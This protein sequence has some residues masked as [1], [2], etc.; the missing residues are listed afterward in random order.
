ALLSWEDRFAH[1]QAV[2]Y[3]LAAAIVRHIHETTDRG[4]A[5]LIFMPGVAEIQATI[6]ALKDIDGVF[7]LPLHAGLSASEQRRVFA[8]PSK[9]EQGRKV[10]VATNIAETS[11]TI[12]DIGFVVDSGRVRELRH[13][14][15]TRVARLTTVL[16][17]QAAAAQRRGRAGRT[18]P[19]VCFRM[20]T[21]AIHERMPLHADPEILR[22]PLEQV[23]L[24][25]KA[26]GHDDPRSILQS[27]L[28]PPSP[29]AIASA[30]Q[31]LVA[32]GACTA[33][34]RPLTALGRFIA[35]IPVD[36]R[37]AKILVYGAMMGVLDDALKIVALMALDKPLFSGGGGDRDAVKQARLR[38]ASDS[39][40][41]GL[42]DWLADLAAY[43]S[44]ADIRGGGGTKACYDACVSPAAIRDVKTNVRQLRD[45]IRH[46]GLVEPQLEGTAAVAASPMVLKALICAG[47]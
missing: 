27:A 29:L 13:D 34:Y 8:K 16:C 12:D 17:S 31:L 44:L 4:L 39:K 5:V 14:H 3:T 28:D 46:T 26:L 33:E 40:R 25:V 32:I 23:C 36:L 10:V 7:V 47:L 37:L 43:N 22:S 45:S 18:Q 2:D 9:P 20:Y 11:I 42:S 19:G 24:R 30:E 35:D 38:F 6:A 41:D 21:R 15:Q 1:A